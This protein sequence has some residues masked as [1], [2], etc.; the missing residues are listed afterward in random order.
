MK[1]VSRWVAAALLATVLG[2]ANA[3]HEA[4]S[5][6]R[7]GDGYDEARFGGETLTVTTRGVAKKVHVSF[8][9][10]RVAPPGKPVVVRLA[11]TGLALV[12]SGAGKSRLTA[13]S[14]SFEPLVGEWLR[15]S[16]PT[17]LGIT[18]DNDTV[19]LDLILVRESGF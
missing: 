9:R 2:P 18:I 15:L 16:L 12:Q 7:T 10:L 14:Q 19:Q 13:S 3:Q 17:E 1:H 6:F 5:P 11:G 4:P 8:M